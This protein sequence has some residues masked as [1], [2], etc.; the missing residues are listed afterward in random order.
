MMVRVIVGINGG[1][2]E[3]MGRMDFIQ[4]GRICFIY[5]NIVELVY[6]DINKV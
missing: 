1:A 2:W 5:I 6:I 4:G 3:L